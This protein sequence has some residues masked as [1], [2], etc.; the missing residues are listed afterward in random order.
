[1]HI[2]FTELYYLHIR[3]FTY[4][5]LLLKFSHNRNKRPKDEF[6]KVKRHRE[7][8]KAHFGGKGVYRQILSG[9]QKD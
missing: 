7:H 3:S 6:S 2:D 5:G 4:T 9:N 1:M 8:D